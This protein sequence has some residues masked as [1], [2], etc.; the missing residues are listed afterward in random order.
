M[1][2][3]IDLTP[4]E[5]A[6]ISSAAKHAGVAPAELVKQLVKEHLPAIPAEIE[7]DLNATLQKWQLRDHSKANPDDATKALFAQWAE[8]DEQLT[9]DERE[10]NERVYAEIEKNGIPRVQI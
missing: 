7:N 10:Q 3:T 1:N 8:E 5:E 2:L 6:Q 4:I 9:D